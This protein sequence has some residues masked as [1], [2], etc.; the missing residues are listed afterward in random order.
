MQSPPAVDPWNGLGLGEV[1]Q[2]RRQSLTGLS[3]LHLASN[4]LRRLA[5]TLLPAHKYAPLPCQQLYA[6]FARSLISGIQLHWQLLS[7]IQQT[8]CTGCRW[9]QQA[10]RGATAP[11]LSL[12]QLR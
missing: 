10:S 1:L 6:K 7:H 2:P 4:S 12:P 8:R 9:W 5:F 3:S 11:C